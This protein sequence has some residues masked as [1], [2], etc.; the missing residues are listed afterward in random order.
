MDMKAIV[1]K[2]LREY[3]SE[4]RLPFDDDYFKNKNYLEQYKDWLEDFGKYGTLPPSTLDFWKESEKAAKIIV[5]KNL[6]G[7]Y[8]TIDDYNEYDIIN[9]FGNIVRPHIIITDDN[10]IY[11]E[12]A[13]RISRSARFYDDSDENGDDPQLLTNKLKKLYNDNVGGCWSYKRNGSQ[14]YCSTDDDG[15]E[16]TL[17]GLIR[18]DDI[19][20]IKTVLLNFHYREEHEIRVKPKA[21]IEI[22]EVKFNCR[23]KIPLKGHLIVN[24]TY[25]GN[26]GKYEGEYAKVDDGFGN[27]DIMDRKGNIDSIENVVKNK[28]EEGFPIEKIFTKIEQLNDYLKVGYFYDKKFLIN[29][30]NELKGGP[31]QNI[32]SFSDGFARVE[33]LNNRRSFIDK[34]GNLIGNGN[35]WFDYA[36]FYNNNMSLVELNGKTSILNKNGELIYNGKVWFDTI[37]RYNLSLFMVTMKGEKYLVDNEGNFYDVQTKKKIKPPFETNES[38]TKNLKDI[39]S[40]TFKAYIKENVI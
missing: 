26:N 10:K 21:K 6:H 23:Y 20:F 13:V 7:R 27:Y 18:T 17:R 28:L 25:F 4:R 3:S 12:R 34:S 19:D 32:S 29:I 15:D 38:S 30:N 1:R 31:Y 22:F 9:E 16:I 24:A 33:S 8:A 5:D 37:S 11:V 35:L 36:S 14:S 40:E 2:M 39:I